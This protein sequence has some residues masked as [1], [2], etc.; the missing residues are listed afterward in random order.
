MHKIL[1]FETIGPSA[2]GCDFC[3]FIFGFVSNLGFRA[4]DFLDCRGIG[5][6]LFLPQIFVKAAN[7]LCNR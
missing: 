3:H 5:A 6:I 4:S 2:R 1:M 7:D